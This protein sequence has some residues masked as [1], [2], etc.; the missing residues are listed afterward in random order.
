MAILKKWIITSVREDVKK[1]E[2]SY[3]A[4]GNENDATAL[5]KSWAAHQKVKLRVTTW[6]SNSIPRS[7][8]K[9]I[10][11]THKNIH[12]NVQKWLYKH[13]S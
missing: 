6:F 11:N 12:K 10:E 3:I 5:E 8:S 7:I 9:K 1:L 13:Y 2:S 4:V